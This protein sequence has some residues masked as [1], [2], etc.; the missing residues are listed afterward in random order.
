MQRLTIVERLI[1]AALL[2]FFAYLALTPIN[3]AIA[4]LD[5]DTV[6]SFVSV[7]ADLAMIGLV[8]LV[9]RTIARTI[10]EPI[11]EA[12]ETIDALAYAEL[13]S[14]PQAVYLDRCEMTRVAS[15]AARLADLM[16]E[17][18]RRELVHDDLDRT[19]QA[20]RRLNLSDMANEVEAAT[21]VGLQPIVE[22]ALTLQAKAEDMRVSLEIVRT[23]FE[24]T[25]IAAEGTIAVN[26]AAAKL[27]DQVIESI[28][29]IAG[30]VAR[31]SDIGRDA[32][33]RANNSRGT[34]AALAKAADDIGE[35]VSVINA[36]AQ[37]TNLLALNATIEAARA[38]E[39]GRGF[40]VVASE[41]KMLA[42]QTGKSTEQIGAKVA[43][44]Q[45]ATRQVVASLVEV[46]EAVDKLSG[47]TGSVSAAVEQQRAATESFSVN[48]RE[49]SLAVSDVA[50]RMADI[51]DMVARSA[52]S[53]NDVASVAADMQTISDT[54]RQAIPE[55]VR[56]AVKADLRE[57][58]RYDVAL[59]A[60]AEFGG[61]RAEVKVFDVS[62]GGARIERA[63]GMD[64]GGA[65]E[66]S[67]RGLRGVT[68]QVVRDTGDSFGI[69][70][71]PS[72]LRPE[73]LRD[74]IAVAA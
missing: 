30:E 68:G 19:W 22:G 46:A 59:M 13:N 67:F 70:F 57:H 29:I 1:V 62:E 18:Q 8:A 63:P 69:S 27:S 33:A 65:V 50:G 64:V 53:A 23:A 55:L 6:V 56:K 44:I 54:M 14:A 31:G 4:A 21:D 17:R 52:K 15:A 12:A 42:T 5:D 35:F 61:Q 25:A 43:E 74:L 32:V 47:V 36:I 60:V 2:P 3:A 9:L 39:S 49:S 58:P 20:S 7:L 34:I 41:V 48:A 73:E 24:E 26:E 10:S 66:L 16:R 28:A 40:S 45:S 51:A 11:T 38:G 72:K 37:Q 71:A